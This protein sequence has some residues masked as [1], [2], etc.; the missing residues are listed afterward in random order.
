MILIDDSGEDIMLNFQTFS[1]F[2]VFGFG[3]D[4]GVVLSAPA[5]PAGRRFLVFLKINDFQI[6]LFGIKKSE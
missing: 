2:E 1:R 4:L 5:L 3:R 6:A